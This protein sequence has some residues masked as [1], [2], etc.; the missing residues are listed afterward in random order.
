M[1]FFYLGIAFLLL[2]RALISYWEWEMWAD[3]EKIKKG[4]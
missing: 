2:C 1:D 3:M 4:G